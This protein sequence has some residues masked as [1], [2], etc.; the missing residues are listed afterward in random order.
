MFAIY[1]NG[2]SGLSSALKAFPDT[3]EVGKYFLFLLCLVK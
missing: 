2:L 3:C 1:L